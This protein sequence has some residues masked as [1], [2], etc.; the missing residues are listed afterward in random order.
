VDRY[1]LNP[2]Q[3]EIVRAYTAIGI[4]EGKFKFTVKSPA[5]EVGSCTDFEL[6]EHAVKK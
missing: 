2:L 4:E 3:G 5:D 6:G 1:R